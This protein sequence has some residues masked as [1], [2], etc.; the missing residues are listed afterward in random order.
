MLCSVMNTRYPNA[1]PEDGKLTIYDSN[2]KYRVLPDG[3]G[4]MVIK[5]KQKID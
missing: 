3:N 5:K 1:K 2:Y 4:G